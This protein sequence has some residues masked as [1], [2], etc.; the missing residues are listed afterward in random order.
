[1][2]NFLKKLFCK[3]DYTWNYLH[4]INGGM[5]KLYRCECKKCG[6]VRYKTHKSVYQK[7]LINREK[8]YYGIDG[9]MVQLVV[10]S[11]ILCMMQK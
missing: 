10:T 1:M 4:M 8:K 7:H 2:I 9:E 11:I 5:A 6:K 3:H